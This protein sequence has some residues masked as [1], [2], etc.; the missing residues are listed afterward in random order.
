MNLYK[1]IGDLKMPD[2]PMNQM[3]DATYYDPKFVL[4]KAVKKAID[5]GWEGKGSKFK[6]WYID[7]DFMN[8]TDVLAVRWL[9]PSGEDN[10]DQFT[11][12]SELM[13]NH[14][15]AKALWG[16]DET[17]LNVNYDAQKGTTR[18][19]T[20]WQEHLREMVIADDPIKYLGE[21]I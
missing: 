19:L 5:K 11:I 14:D 2:E 8:Q 10:F 1:D 3:A 7:S 12:F 15:F 4:E 9:D 21:N 13:Y 16:D 6:A 17:N 18:V 20:D